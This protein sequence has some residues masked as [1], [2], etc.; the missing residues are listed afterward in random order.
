MC[1]LIP[2]NC[3]SHPSP[4]A[5]RNGRSDDDDDGMTET[6]ICHFIRVEPYSSKVSKSFVSSSANVG[7]TQQ[8]PP[9]F[10]LPREERDEK[11]VASPSFLL[12]AHLGGAGAFPSRRGWDQERNAFYRFFFFWRPMKEIY[13]GSLKGGDYRTIR[14]REGGI[15]AVKTRRNLLF[16]HSDSLLIPHLFCRESLPPPLC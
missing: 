11:F 2:S 6:D 14:T 9:S 4:T 1:N 5:Q 7:A 10:L 8:R 3:C 16:C 13:F 15:I 12:Y